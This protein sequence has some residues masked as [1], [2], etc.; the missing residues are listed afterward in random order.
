[1]KIWFISD[2]H[3]CHKDLIVP[4]YDI[5]IHSGDESNNKDPHI[6]ANESIDFFEWYESLPGIKVFTPGNHSTAIYHGL[7]QPKNYNVRTLI[8]E[9]DIIEGIKIW[10][11]PYTPIYGESWAYMMGRHKMD[12]VW[13][14]IR[15][16]DILVTHG[17]PKGIM[18]LS[19]TRSKTAGTNKRIG[20]IVQVGC[21]KL[22]QAA[23]QINTKIHCFGHIH[24]ADNFANTGILYR[25][26]RIYVNAATTRISRDPAKKTY[27]L[28]NNGFILEYPC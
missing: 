25:P 17:P 12:I 15:D 19:V 6:N 21:G 7:V 9:L 18:D 1:M 14:L 26:E 20:E 13:N 10:A 4:E 2:T 22:A 24:E 28:C 8:N 23:S 11:S 27:E 5:V 3:G 16:C